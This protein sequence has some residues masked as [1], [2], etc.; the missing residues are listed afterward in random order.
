MEHIYEKVKANSKFLKIIGE[1][2][3]MTGMAT[4]AGAN[5]G[6][7]PTEPQDPKVITANKLK[8][9]AERKAAQAELIAL[10]AK[11]N[12][13]RVSVPNEQQRKRNLQAIIAGKPIQVPTK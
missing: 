9:D 12:A 8:M 7:N 5:G 6:T 4:S 3:N 13:D 1:Y 2:T 10:Q 11:T